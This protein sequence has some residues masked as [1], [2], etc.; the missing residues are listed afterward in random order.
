VGDATDNLGIA[1]AASW[2]DRDFGSDNI[3]TDGGWPNDLEA[4]DPDT[5][6]VT[7]FK[8]AEEIEQ[9]SYTVNRERTGVA[10]NFDLRGENGQ[11]YLR[12]LYSSFSDQEYR[13]RNEYKF[14]DGDAISGT[15]TSA[16]WQGAVVEKS[17]KD[18]L[19]EQNIL[20]VLVG[21]ENYRGSWT[22]DYSFGHSMGEELEPGRLDTTFEI[23]D[24]DIG[25]T[26]IG[27]IPNLTSDPLMDDPDNFALAE[28]EYLDG[29][30]EDT[31]N[32]LKFNVTNELFSD[33]YNG[34]I[35]FG[36]LSRARE[37]TYNATVIIYDG[38]DET[39]APF[40]TSGPRYGIGDFG[41]G[42]NESAI[43]QY[44]F[45]NQDNL[46]IDEEDSL[47]GS[48]GADY[49]IN[50]DVNAA[51]LMS[52]YETENLRI[53][54]GVRYEDTAFDA[55]GLRIVTDEIN[56]DGS[57]QAEPV[58]FKKD[59]DHVL[60]GINLRFERG[61][62]IFRAAA[63]RTIARPNFDEL[64]PGGE[65][66]FED[67]DGENVF[68]A[69][70]GNPLLDP[71]EAT[72]LDFGVEWY[73]GGVSV[74]S[75]GIFYKELENFIITADV[76]EIVDL[77]QWVGD[78]PVDDAEVIQPINGDKGELFGVEAA[79]V[80]QFENGLYVSGNATFVDSEASYFNRDTTTA[81][82]RTPELVV[83]GAIG[84]ENRTLSLRLA[85]TYRDD[86]L[87]GFEDLDDPDFD[88]YQD[89]HLQ[90][91]LSAKWN[92]TD[93]LQ[94][95]FAAINLTDEPYYNYFGSRQYNAQYEEYGRTFSLGLR[96]TPF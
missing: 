8:G 67:D 22:F 44:F 36:V 65:I 37:K 27:Q 48:L 45:S 54:Y 12:N 96:Y 14:D 10:L 35:K 34:N 84:W 75:A 23:E 9:R 70:I 2:Y 5:Q 18:R 72:N 62:T 21:G 26:S 47:I 33:A 73:P 90:F 49:T 28:F 19:E 56:G 55:T 38:P 20:S 11:W 24:V 15:S 29:K 80:Q 46:E 64:R 69:E 94:L 6:V 41:P 4:E 83:N 1:F 16:Q 79:I 88:V 32:T 91:D 93:A 51:Y 61:N 31:A 42:I 63:T 92:I 13:N 60:P 59:Y 17:L 95:S 85:A 82:P 57:A 3:E 68:E 87:Q 78:T 77:T 58:S 30:A 89:E 86:A 66:V 7:E 76:A 74:V 52:T 53:V 81:L 71:V 25:Y 39:L 43:R 50:E 40:A